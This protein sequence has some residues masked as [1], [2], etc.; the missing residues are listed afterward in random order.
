MPAKK[1]KK[2]AVAKNTDVKTTHRE[3]MVE[4][5]MPSVEWLAEMAAK[6][7]SMEPH[8]HS[9]RHRG[10]DYGW[11]DAAEK[12]Y[13]AYVGA[14]QFLHQLQ[15]QREISAELRKIRQE[16]EVQL[17]PDDTLLDMV[18]YHLACKTITGETRRDRAEEG[19]IKLT[20]WLHGQ[21]FWEDPETGNYEPPPDYRREKQMG[22]GEVAQFKRQYG[23]M[24][25]IP[26]NELAWTLR[27]IGY[28]PRQKQEKAG[29]KSPK[30]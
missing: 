18:E 7:W 2:P 29:Q 23:H 21:G 13:S 8:C 10:I 26:K 19:F 12:A 1:R 6:V 27:Q 25:K 28:K 20:T 15:I 5:P 16:I 22:V 4:P 3:R 17:G 30:S 11:V 9:I 24:K 14:H